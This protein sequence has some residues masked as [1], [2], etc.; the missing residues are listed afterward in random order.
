VQVCT[1]EALGYR[2]I[3]RLLAHFLKSVGQLGMGRLL[4]FKRFHLGTR[5]ADIETYYRNVNDAGFRFVPCQIY[6]TL[7]ESLRHTRLV[8]IFT[9][10]S[11]QIRTDPIGRCNTL[12]PW[13]HL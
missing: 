10:I 5:I 3:G 12:R 11:I 8:Q 6:L 9:L 13:T 4:A 1:P 7:V 2:L